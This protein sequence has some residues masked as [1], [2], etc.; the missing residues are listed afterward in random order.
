[1]KRFD[2][3]GFHPRE[4]WYREMKRFGILPVATQA[5][6]PVDYYALEREYWKSLWYSPK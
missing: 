2:M 3:P 5:Q 6:Q 4:A 1:V